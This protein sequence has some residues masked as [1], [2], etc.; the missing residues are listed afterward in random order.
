MGRDG[1]APS[2]RRL[3]SSGGSSGSGGR[4]E[5]LPAGYTLPPRSPKL[6]GGGGGEQ[7]LG[8]GLTLARFRAQ[9]DDLWEH[10]AHVELILSTFGT[11]PRVNLGY[12]GGK[13]SLN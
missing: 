6:S 2:H 1:R 9:L 7:G 12:M 11:H 5:G 4:D 13:V 3:R 10:I 8:Q